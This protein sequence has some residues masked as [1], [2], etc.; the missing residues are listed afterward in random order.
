MPGGRLYPCQGTC[1]RMTRNSKMPK[2]KYPDAVIRHSST[3]C[4]SCHAALMREQNPDAAAEKRERR[5]AEDRAKREA[6]YEAAFRAHAAFLRDRQ[7]RQA[8]QARR[9]RVSA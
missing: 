5:A 2:H 7:A 6:G 3:R 1:G 4:S 8:R 9:N